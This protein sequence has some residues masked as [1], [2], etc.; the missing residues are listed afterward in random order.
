[1]N[2]VETEKSPVVR[3]QLELMV[4]EADKELNNAFWGEKGRIVRKDPLD[5][6]GPSYESEE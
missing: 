3:V 2:Q 1:M 6:Q 5:G 4:V